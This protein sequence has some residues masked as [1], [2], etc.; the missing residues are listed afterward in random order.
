MNNVGYIFT[1]EY[2]YVNGDGTSFHQI[3]DHYYSRKGDNKYVYPKSLVP[4]YNEGGSSFEEFTSNTVSGFTGFSD[5]TY[6][7]RDTY[8]GPDIFREIKQILE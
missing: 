3:K 8:L 4:P 5:G 2:K 7:Y 1:S 6:V